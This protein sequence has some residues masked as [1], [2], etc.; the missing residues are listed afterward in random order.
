M[1]SSASAARALAVSGRRHRT[2]GL[3]ARSLHVRQLEW[4]PWRLPVRSMPSYLHSPQS[5]P[6]LHFPNV[7][8]PSAFSLLRRA[9]A[10]A[11]R[12]PPRLSSTS[13][14]FECPSQ[15]CNCSS[16]VRLRLTLLDF[17]VTLIRRAR[18]SDSPFDPLDPR[19]LL[20]TRKTSSGPRS[21]TS[22]RPGP[23]SVAVR[24]RCAPVP[25]RRRVS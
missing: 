1:P 15:V 10:S 20:R 4:R 11:L 7:R 6:S 3:E 22:I 5:S 14:C 21:S 24:L 13:A 8:L 18:F 17:C 12:L 16:R 2:Q 9:Q 25:F 19:P 23:S